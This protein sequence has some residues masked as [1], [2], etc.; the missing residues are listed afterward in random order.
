MSFI[1]PSSYRGNPRTRGL[2]NRGGYCRARSFEGETEYTASNVSRG[3]TAGTAACVD[4]QFETRERRIIDALTMGG[5]VAHC[6]HQDRAVRLPA[7]IIRK[8]SREHA[9]T[10]AG[11]HV[12]SERYCVVGSRRD[13]TPR[14]PKIRSG[15]VFLSS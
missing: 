11:R 3:A 1:Y 4:L 15:S 9:R 5:R 14:A 12:T 8:R 6:L 10:H 7:S 13:R 2:R